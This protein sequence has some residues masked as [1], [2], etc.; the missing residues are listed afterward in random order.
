MKKLIK[1]LIGPSGKINSNRS[2]RITV[3]I[4]YSWC[5]SKQEY[6]FA[7]NNNLVSPPKCKKCNY[8]I[9][10]FKSFKNGYNIFCCARCRENDKDKI[11][12]SNE[13]IKMTKLSRY[14]D[15]NYCNV[16]K[17]KMTKLNRYGDENYN[18]IE[19]YKNTCL[20]KYGV[21]NISKIP[22][23]RN[24]AMIKTRETREKL[25]HWVTL[26]NLSLYKL[27]K[28]EVYRITN[29]MNISSLNN[30][31]KR[32]MAGVNGKYH[33]DHKFSILQGYNNGILPIYIGNIHN[34]EMIPW[35]ENYNKKANSSISLEELFTK[36]TTENS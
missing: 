20:I 32:G 29:S 21:N 33:L 12:K 13:Q 25:N 8:N 14:G 17:I 24:K 30:I 11:K 27:Y 6:Y 1:W 28:R 18:N 5:N 36:S 22:E 4:K 34:L 16:D 7:F 19:K 9:V 23:V 35:E 10:K 15:E 26:E 3:P 31:D 2:K